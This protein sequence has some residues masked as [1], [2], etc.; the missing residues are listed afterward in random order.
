MFD[1]HNHWVTATMQLKTNTWYVYDSLA[2]AGE[3]E[4][5]FAIK[6]QLRAVSKRSKTQFTLR[7]IKIQNASDDC[8]LFAIASMVDIAFGIDPSTQDYKQESMRRHLVNCFTKHVMIPF[9]KIQND[10]CGVH[11]LI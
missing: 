3:C 11:V 7:K 4:V 6:K 10:F 2:D 8:R 9:P 5:N 1:N